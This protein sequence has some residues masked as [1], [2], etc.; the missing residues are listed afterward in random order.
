MDCSF[1]WLNCHVRQRPSIVCFEENIYRNLFKLINRLVAR[2]F[3]RFEPF[4]SQSKSVEFKR[5]FHLKIKCW[6]KLL[7]RT[8]TEMKTVTVKYHVP[9]FLHSLLWTSAYHYFNQVSLRTPNL[10]ISSEEFRESR[11]WQAT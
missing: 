8:N 9:Q 6:P 5:A 2:W 11:D 4:C 10:P 7:T 1:F 3:A